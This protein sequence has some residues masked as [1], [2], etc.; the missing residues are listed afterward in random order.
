M[1]NRQQS[2][3]P[4]RRD[5]GGHSGRI[6]VRRELALALAAVSI[7]L[8]MAAPADGAEILLNFKEA[9]LRTVLEY[10]SEEAGLVILGG[11]EVDGRITVISRQPISTD[12]AVALLDSVLKESGYAAIR[13]GRTLK[14]VTVDEAVTSNLPVFTGNDPANVPATDKLVTQ[15]IPVRYAVAAKLKTDLAP[16]ISDEATF[17]INEASNTLILVDTQANIRR[18]MQVIQALD[19]SMAGV[20]EV[21]VYKLEN[22]NAS[23]AATLIGKL[24][25]QESSQQSSRS[26]S[27][28]SRFGMMMSSRSRGGDD[29]SR[30][31]SGQQGA[32]KQKVVATADERTNTLVV[33]ASPESIKVIDGIIEELESNPTEKESVFIYPLK[34]A[35]A[36]NLETVVNSIFSESTS[37][38]GR[39]GTSGS[40]SSRFGGYYRGSSSSRGTGTPGA[41]DLIGQVYVVADEDT[42][43]LLVR[44]PSK[45]FD[46]VKGILDELDRPIRQVLIKVLLAEVTHE[47]VTDLGAEFSALNIRVGS[48]N[49]TIGTDFSVASQSG[50]LIAKVVDADY[51]VTLRALASVGKLDVLSRPYILASDNQEANITVGQEVPFIRNT[52]TTD[53]GQTI[54]T[55][56]Y[57]DIGIILSVTPHIN[58]DGL[59]ILDVAPEISTLTG[60]TV[61]ISET[62]NA[63]VFAKRS[64][65]TRVAIRNGQTIVIGGLM[66]DRHTDTITKV[67]LLGDIPLLGA[68]FRRTI[69]SK[70]KTELLIFLTPHVADE[71]DMLREMSKQEA[72]GSRAV[73]DATGGGAFAEHMAGMRRG[74]T[75]LRGRPTTRPTTWPTTRPTTR[76][77]G[78]PS[79]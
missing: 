27:P 69:K 22:A 46:R 50:G 53:T 64:A 17:T 1:M 33:S 29:R 7:L 28:F 66:E 68:L 14:I 10:L 55:I 23:D 20:T 59:V 60:T 79:P 56:E 3:R 2:P 65:K 11:D 47:S 31:G 5:L 35:Q 75:T 67:P 72:A 16:L 70:V 12:E 9:P 40:T 43:S 77:S 74:A 38:S 30:G 45:Y 57:E 37:T 63:A 25:G 42:N 48:S 58:P 39:G 71:P 6:G 19:E 61:P 51:T 21:K 15:I 32:A 62:V 52:R 49:S 78:I 26:S 34:N 13:T 24:F 8:A 18:I 73:R 44:T 36:A 76:P 54:N 4:G 41:G